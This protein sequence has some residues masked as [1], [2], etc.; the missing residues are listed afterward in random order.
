MP[1]VPDGEQRLARAIVEETVF[2]RRVAA[3]AVAGFFGREFRWYSA[4][5]PNGDHFVAYRA[6]H[7][8]DYVVRRHAL[9][10]RLVLRA[11]HVADPSGAPP[12]DY[13]TFWYE[14]D[15]IV[16]GE[17]VQ[18]VGKGALDCGTREIFVWSM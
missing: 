8:L 14:L 11:F 4:T 5:I 2:R 6:D 17:A 13:V 3:P 1:G 9:G 10:D 15:R 16:D 7:A 18:R 12:R